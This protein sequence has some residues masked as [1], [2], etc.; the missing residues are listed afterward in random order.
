MK[1]F[2]HSHDG[3]SKRGALI[4]VL[5]FVL[6]ATALSQTPP[7]CVYAGPGS[8]VINN[9]GHNYVVG[10]RLRAVGGTKCIEAFPF[11]LQVTAVNANGGVTAATII[12]GDSNGY[13]T[14]PANP[15]AFS[16]SATGSDFRAI[17]SF[18]P[19]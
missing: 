5:A 7:P 15:V 2:L 13:L 16:G 12:G 14:P 4:I 8:M 6:R 19:R 1:K 17:F 18:A 3:A 9:A 10:D 11:S